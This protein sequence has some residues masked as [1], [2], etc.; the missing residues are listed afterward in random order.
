MTLAP[1]RPGTEPD[2]VDVE[3]LVAERS[4]LKGEARELLGVTGEGGPAPRFRTVLKENSVGY[5]PLAA[6]GTLSIVD[7][8]QGFAFSVLTPE[9]SRSLGLGL[10]AISL[11]LGLKTLAS[12]LAPLPTAAFVQRVPRRALVIIVSAAAWAIATLY[13]G[14]TTSVFLLAIVLVL[15]GLSTGAAGTLTQPLLMDSYPPATRVRVFSYATAINNLGNVI[16]PLLVALLAAVL[17]FTWR[18]VFLIFGIMCVAVLP[19][20]LRL[21]DPGFGKF[22]TEKVRATVHHQGEDLAEDDVSLGF[23][24]ITRRLLLI[25]TVRK[26]LVAFAVFGILLIP[27]SAFLS[28]YL[29]ETLNFGPGQR[30]LFFAL[31]SI[32]SIVALAIYGK[33]GEAMFRKDPGRVLDVAGLQLIV[34]VVLISLAVLSPWT[35]LTL[36]L[37]TLS[38]AITAVLGPALA[39]A[40]L[41][42]VPA[43]MRPHAGALYGIFAAGV[44]GIAGAVLLGGIQA[45]YGIAGALFSLLV[46]GI[47]GAILL[48]RAAPY[49]QRDMDRM[50]D[51]VLEDEQL[52]LVKAA[53]GRLP[54]LSCKGID[55]SYGQLQ[56]LFGVD[57]T[58]DDGE[59]V[60]LLGTNGA[61]KSTLLKV[62]SGIGLPT[63]GNV[64]YRGQ[65]ITYLD[66][67]RRTRLGIT[68]IPG[69]RSVF[70]PLTVIENLRS[71]GYTLGKERKNLDALI[72]DC[73]VAFPRLA[74]RRNSL[75]AQL[76]GGEQQMLGLSK[77]LIM[78]PRVLVIDEL[79]LGLAPIIVGQLLEMV[80]NINATGTAVVLVE[81]S[82]NI[83]LNL[84]DHA[85]FME[86]GEMRFDGRAADL[87][88]RDDLLR[89]VFLE[90]AGAAK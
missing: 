69:G 52:K 24:E 36:T 47:G 38:T 90:G 55:F 58:V 50:I 33:R 62:I 67:E 48:R 63:S 61:G 35:W 1:E 32:S 89:A 15:D 68:Q 19:L 57:F 26:L 16:A 12:A 49:V 59:M 73:L 76:S 81:Q 5:Y 28:F 66:A 39:I 84:V 14:F 53:G 64:R 87:L 51:E 31:T 72:D 78:K 42:I 45:R 17:G 27:F 21:R 18:G 60:A 43:Q 77:A 2:V 85:Y 40:L 82:V 29:D 75:A 25:P 83:A 37:F 6:L 79:S 71:Y 46:P 10:G 65:D 86:K 88:A 56:V 80:R 13:T 20:T 34:G 41:S 3:D 22:D 7:S 30:G 11:L 54:M 9:I 8:L 70:G 44:G 23:F 74:E 4:R